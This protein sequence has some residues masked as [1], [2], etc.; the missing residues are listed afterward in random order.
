M[1]KCFR[2]AVKNIASLGDTDVFPYPIDNA[3]FFD[4]QNEVV[5]LL[6]EMYRTQPFK[7]N[8][9]RYPLVFD[10]E[11]VAAGYLG[12]RN[13]TQIDPLWNALLLGTVLTIGSEIES[14]RLNK[15]D[16]VVF[17]YRYAPDEDSGSLFDR[18]IG[19]HDY[20]QHAVKLAEDY[21]F[22]VS[23]DISNF[24]PRIYHHRLENALQRTTT[25]AEAIKKII[26]ILTEL[27]KG[28]SYGLPVGGPASRILSEL[29]LNNV[30]TLLATNNI[31]FARYV[32]DFY[33]F[34]SSKGEA[35]RHLVFLSEKLLQ[36]EGLSLQKAKTKIVSSKEFLATSEFVEHNESL[37]EPERVLRKFRKV[38]LHFD[39][40]SITADEDYET[41]KQAVAEFDIVGM[42]RS[43]L[44]KT[45]I[46]EPTARKLL[47]AI[48]ALNADVQI[49]AVRTV[50]DNLERLIPVF[51]KVA[52]LLKDIVRLG[53]GEANEEVFLG[54]HKLFS[55][56]SPVVA[57]PVNAA[58]AVRVLAY[59]P[60]M[61]TDVLLNSL[62][63]T[64]NSIM[65]RRDVINV[66]TH[67]G[68]LAWLSDKLKDYS[69]VGVWEKRALLVASFCLTDE[70]AH[71]RRKVVTNK[72]ED[73]V[74]DWAASRKQTNVA[75]LPV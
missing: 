28:T 72:Y 54:L 68:A 34:A 38:K 40:Y 36:N 8:F 57:L 5:D 15:S 6:E 33:I 69:T 60:E 65:L 70:G 59:D 61:R 63:R 9:D 7:D 37:G 18:E 11:L 75:G 25:N 74:R 24:Y 71:W 10:T 35:Y 29:L 41:L 47:T 26:Q 16:Q 1:R 48:K 58:Y 56:T 17:S 32:D 50:L 73:I 2:L 19:W 64:A 20:Q 27:S 49:G 42:L 13:V 31:Q 46:H 4:R 44:R 23:C 39:P 62:Y 14:Q 45:R 30:D 53:N 22:V 12:F 66:M 51:P 55:E 67:R 21:D 43:E 52:L 3:I